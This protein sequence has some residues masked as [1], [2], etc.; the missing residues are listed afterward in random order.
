MS[1]ELDAEVARGIMGIA[2][3]WLLPNRDG[4][5]PLCLAAGWRGITE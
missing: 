4:V 2:F 5:Q 3:A 1:S